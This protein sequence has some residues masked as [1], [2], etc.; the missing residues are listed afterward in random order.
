MS[1]TTRLEDTTWPWSLPFWVAHR[2]AGKLAPENT[3]ALL[4][5]AASFE[6]VK[7]PSTTTPLAWFAR[8]PGCSPNSLVMLPSTG[9]GA[10]AL[11]VMP[12]FAPSSA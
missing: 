11:H 1:V 8:L 4:K 12:C 2:G 7:L 9:P 3:L 6:G 5:V 10:T